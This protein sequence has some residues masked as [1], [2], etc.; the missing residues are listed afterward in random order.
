MSR[1]PSWDLL[2]SAV[3]VART[4]SLS[5]AARA[6]GVTQ[7][8][9]RRHVEALEGELG[10]RLF[11]RSPSGL[12]PTPAAVAMLPF[13][14]TIDA[15]VAAMVRATVG[16]GTA[17]IGPV[18]L[19][20][21]EV[22]AV[23]VLPRLI[24]PLLVANPTL[25]IELVATDQREDI[26]RRDA[27]IA[28]RM[29]RPEEGALVAR[30]VAKVEVGLFATAGYLARAGT[31]ETMT[32]LAHHVLVGED[33][34]TG[35]A[36]ALEAA[37][38]QRGELRF[39]LRTDS[40]PAQLQAVR[41]GVGI[42]TCQVPLAGREPQ[43]VRVLPGIAVPLD[44]WLVTHADLCDQPRIRLVMDGLL[45]GLRDHAAGGPGAAD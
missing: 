29:A 40:Q 32:D 30:R 41:A 24:A 9:V 31:P 37:G 8:T 15:T 25:E 36:A 4:G 3:A 33:R 38:A 19:T 21:S 28:L 16:D 5:A 6:L 12:V 7:P 23:E 10:I 13:A 27:D 1:R 22:M 17:S 26:L 11:T 39:T 45:P 44:M 42:G 2:A 35:L 20:A 18:R 34:S 43:L 14:E